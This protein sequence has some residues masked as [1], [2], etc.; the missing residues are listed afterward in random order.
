[1]FQTLGAQVV[2]I[3]ARVFKDME[4]VISLSELV[5]V[6]RIQS[7]DTGQEPCVE[8]ATNGTLELAAI[9]LFSLL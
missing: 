8:H 9:N 7:E 1:M 6:T 4:N 3:V 2:E 5:C